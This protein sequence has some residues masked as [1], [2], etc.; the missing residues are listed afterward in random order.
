MI[1]RWVQKFLPV[2]RTLPM[3]A[4]TLT[5]PWK[6][7]PFRAVF[8]LIQACPLGPVVVFLSLQRE[9]LRSYKPTLLKML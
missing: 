9:S 3:S 8:V 5:L 7:G 1:R 2:I 6:S 4:R